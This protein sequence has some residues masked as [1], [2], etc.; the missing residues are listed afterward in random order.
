MTKK[1]VLL[2]IVLIVV[3]SCAYA[4]SFSAEV[5]ASPYS[6]QYIKCDDVSFSSKYGFGFETGLR[7]HVKDAFCMGL[8]IKYSN[9]SYTESKDNYQVLYSL[10]PYVGCNL[11][12]NDKWTVTTD[13]GFGI[14]ERI[15]GDLRSFFAGVNL[16]LGAGYAI[17]EKISITA[18]ADFGLCYQRESVD[19]SVDTML[20]A[21][22]TL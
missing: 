6:F 2:A 17:N 4:A 11:N 12:V 13:L 18:G 20:G 16:Y 1:S 21:R 3:L 10:M 14:Q 7:F 5:K 9:Y 22:F 8:N 15:L 19:T